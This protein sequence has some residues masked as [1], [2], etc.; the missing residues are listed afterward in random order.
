MSGLFWV[1]AL[2]CAYFTFHVILVIVAT[3]DEFW[4]F[5]TN[6]TY[7][8]VMINYQLLFYAHL[9][10]G[11]YGKTVYRIPSTKE[12]SQAPYTMYRTCT[13]LYEFGI[14]MT[15]TVAF[16]FWLIEFPALC[17]RGDAFEWGF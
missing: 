4:K 10:N 16:A 7:I 5:L 11:D 3:Y 13:F 1:R 15:L 17:L 2:A 12:L 14:S 8:V 9:K 6:L